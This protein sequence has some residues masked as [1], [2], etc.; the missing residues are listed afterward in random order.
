MRHLVFQVYC[1]YDQSINTF[2][3]RDIANMNRIVNEQLILIIA[4]LQEIA[5]ANWAKNEEK[6][7]WS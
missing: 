7:T 1:N 6:Q 4:S 3:V 5:N 2:Y